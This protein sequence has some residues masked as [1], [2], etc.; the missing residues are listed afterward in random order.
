[1]EYGVPMKDCRGVGLNPEP[2]NLVCNFENGFKPDIGITSVSHQ[3]GLGRSPK[4][5]A[6]Y[7]SLVEFFPLKGNNTLPTSPL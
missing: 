2:P 5:V 7:T 6:V 4:V 1:M 3:I